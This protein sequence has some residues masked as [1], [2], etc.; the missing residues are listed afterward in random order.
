MLLPLPI[1][2]PAAAKKLLQLLVA[3]VA[4]AGGIVSSHMA[5]FLIHRWFGCS[6]VLGSLRASSPCIG[7]PARGLKPPPLAQPLP[8]ARAPLER[9]PG[10]PSLHAGQPVLLPLTESLYVSGTLESVD[11]VLLEIG[12]GYYVEV[13]GAAGPVAALPGCTRP[14]RSWVLLTRAPCVNVRQRCGLPRNAALYRSIPISRKPPAPAPTRRPPPPPPH[15]RSATW[16]AAST[17][18]AAR[19]TWCGTRWSS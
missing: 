9:C 5:A 6:C 19:S 13:R 15:D 2:R 12:T 17:T 7:M 3:A 18:A 1:L 8:D 11:T 16:R 4:T 10:P 14:W